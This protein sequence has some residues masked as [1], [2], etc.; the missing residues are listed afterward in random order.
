MTWGWGCLALLTSQLE[1]QE[2]GLGLHL[3]PE[4]SFPVLLMATVTPGSQVYGNGKQRSCL[5]NMESPLL[6]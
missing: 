6:G 4:R 5:V 3:G 2:V 1:P